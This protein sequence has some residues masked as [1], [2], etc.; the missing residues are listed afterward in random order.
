M[1]E[2]LKKVGY[3]TAIMG[4]WH[5]GFNIV[6]KDGQELKHYDGRNII[7]APVGAVV[8][9]GP[10]TRGFDS[11]IGFHHAASIG[12]LIEDDT[13][14][15]HIDPV[16]M[17]PLLQQR[18]CDYIAKKAKEDN[19]FFLYLPLNSP[20]TPIVPSKEWVGKSGIGKYG[21]FVMQTDYVVGQVMKALQENGIADNTLVFFTSDNG[22]CFLATH[23]EKLEKKFGHYS[24]AQFRGGKSD[25]WEGGHRV[26]FI[27][28]W[29]GHIQANTKSKAV[30]CLTNLMATCAEITGQ[31][32]PETV[33]ED[34]YSILPILKDVSAKSNYP[35]VIHHSINGKF[36]IR[37]GPWKLEMCPGSGGWSGPKDMKARK[38]GLPEIQL[39]NMDTDEGERENVYAQHPDI[40][41]ELTEKLK[42]I[43]LAGR[44]TPGSKEKNDVPVDFLKIDE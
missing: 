36:S 5:L 18:A 24:S 15:A 21:D 26:P 12:T 34:S 33:G 42:E 31:K 23:G 40:V 20:H 14:S 17:L 37:K 30:I 7:Q 44:S 43:V 29:P 32:Y 4:K 3:N 9:E 38:L 10:I 6:S 19:P 16:E 1:P 2:L 11:F 8:Q 28:R 25:I 27:V 22:C 13:V 41:K 35:L 39:Y